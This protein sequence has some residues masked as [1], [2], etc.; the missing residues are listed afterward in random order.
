MQALC[1]CSGC[2]STKLAQFAEVMLEMQGHTRRGGRL[3]EGRGNGTNELLGQEGK[4]CLQKLGEGRCGCSTEWME[5]RY[6]GSREGERVGCK[7]RLRILISIPRAS[8]TIDVC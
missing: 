5:W 2:M 4:R 8:Q 1:S 7:V 6:D 3:L